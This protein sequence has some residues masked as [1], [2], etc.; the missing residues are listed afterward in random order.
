MC[1]RVWCIHNM[2]DKKIEHFGRSSENASRSL[3][4]SY[5]LSCASFIY[6]VISSVLASFRC[7]Q[8]AVL[9]LPFITYLPV[10]NGRERAKSCLCLCWRC[11]ALE[12]W[13]CVHLSKSRSK[14]N[15]FGFEDQWDAPGSF[16]CKSNNNLFG[17][18]N[19]AERN[20]WSQTH[21][22]FLHGKTI[23]YSCD[24]LDNN[25]QIS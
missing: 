15:L 7:I 13:P 18:C 24:W 9:W 19:C 14:Q 6:L 20:E 11:V 5:L 1:A 2:C 17:H 4:F 23:A 3:V 22:R 25:W 8:I 12:S 16:R 10:T 21:S